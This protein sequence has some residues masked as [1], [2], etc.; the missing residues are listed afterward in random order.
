MINL[1]L[2]ALTV[3]IAF[4]IYLTLTDQRVRYHD[5]NLTD[6]KGPMW[7]Q[8][9]AWWQIETRD[10]E[11][12]RHG[13]GARLEWSVGRDSYFFVDLTVLDDEGDDIQIG[14]GLPWLFRVWFTLTYLPLFNRIPYKWRRNFGYQTGLRIYSGA[15]WIQVLY[16]EMWGAASVWRR[17]P[18]WISVWKSV[19]YK[20]YR[21]VGFY[22]SFNFDRLIFGSYERSEENIGEPIIREI[23]IEPD[24]RLG[25]RYAGTFQ[26][27][28]EVRW[29]GN[30]PGRK[31]IAVYW[32]IEVE[33][34]PLHAGKGENSYD[35]DDDG[36]ISTSA[37]VET[38]EEA[39][40]DYQER[41]YR[42][43]EKYGMPSVIYNAQSGRIE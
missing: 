12:W 25:L 3:W 16:A 17:S 10:T 15:I 8:G 40:A 39:V 35:Q 22:I 38:I 26:R 27:Q 29:R 6:G 32:Q 14:L 20:E 23:P 4:L 24:N 30:F 2:A 7:R 37:F 36:I 11:H 31:R 43:R 9:R 13:P 21:G 33:E 5:Q 28:K 19:G 42:D 34:P 41:V 1:I 18:T